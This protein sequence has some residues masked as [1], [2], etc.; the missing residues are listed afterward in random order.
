M[1]RDGDRPIGLRLLPYDKVPD[2]V[3]ILSTRF[4]SPTQAMAA[5]VFYIEFDLEGHMIIND[6]RIGK[7]LNWLD[8]FQIL[9]AAAPMLI[10]LISISAILSSLTFVILLLHIL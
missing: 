4:S 2:S 3:H 6:Q 5:L 1:R 7:Q 9:F 8:R 10:G